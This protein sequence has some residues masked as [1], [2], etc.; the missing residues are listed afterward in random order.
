MIE[1]LFAQDHLNIFKNKKSSFTKIIL[2][3]GLVHIAGEKTNEPNA[4]KFDMRI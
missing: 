2:F 3:C 1:N 4:M